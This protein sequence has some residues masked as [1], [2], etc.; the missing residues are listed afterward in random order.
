MD[1]I[2]PRE[3][4]PS[5]FFFSTL[6]AMK[7]L[8]TITDRCLQGALADLKKNTLNC[9]AFLIALWLHWIVTP[10]IQQTP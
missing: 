2:F 8:W 10:K 9:N 5:L 7:G 1:A 6:G 4:D 3:A